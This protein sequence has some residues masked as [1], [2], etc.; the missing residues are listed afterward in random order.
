MISGF[1]WR[2]TKKSVPAFSASMMGEEL[3][4]SFFSG[5]VNSARSRAAYACFRD[6]KVGSGFYGMYLYS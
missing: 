6:K 3:L 1:K 5:G 4:A 2:L